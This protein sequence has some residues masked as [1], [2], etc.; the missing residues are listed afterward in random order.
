MLIKVL[1]MSLYQNPPMYGNFSKRFKADW[2]R[3]Y[4]KAYIFYKDK[5]RAAET[6]WT[7]AKRKYKKSTKTGKWVLKET[8]IKTKKAGSKAKTLGEKAVKGTAHLY[9]KAKRK[10]K[11]V[12][13]ALKD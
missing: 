1:K 8:A 12:Y 2:K 3:Y 11:R 5:E 7:V 6:A 10:T 13:K 4:D 9:K